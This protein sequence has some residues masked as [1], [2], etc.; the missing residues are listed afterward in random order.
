[1]TAASRTTSIGPGPAKRKYMVLFEQ[2][3]FEALDRLAA[4][5][6]R[7]VTGLVNRICREYLEARG[8]ML[9]DVKE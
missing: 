9:K 3:V 5:E 8:L 1:M 6:D 2:D 7:K 4:E